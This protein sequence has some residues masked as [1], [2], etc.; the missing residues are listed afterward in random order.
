MVI[1][2]PPFVFTVV[3]VWVV[4]VEVVVDRA[5][6]VQLLFLSARRLTHR[7]PVERMGADDQDLLRR[8]GGE[9]F[10]EAP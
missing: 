2:I 10:P 4:I 5:F 8:H 6:A 1:P 7:Q 3:V 9:P